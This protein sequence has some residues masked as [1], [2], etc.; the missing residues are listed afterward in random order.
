MNEEHEGV[1]LL[2]I[3]LY[4]YK[5]NGSEILRNQIHTNY[6]QKKRLECLHYFQHKL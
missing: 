1:N 3:M 4:I 5:K 2:L 6:N